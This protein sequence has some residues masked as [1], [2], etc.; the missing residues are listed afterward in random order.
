MQDSLKLIHESLEGILNKIH[1]AG[2]FSL[3]KTYNDE[4]LWAHY[5]NSHKGF[6]IE[7]DTNILTKNKK[8]GFDLISVH[9]AEKPPKITIQDFLDLK[10]KGYLGF[11]QKLIGT[12]SERWLYEQET[13]IITDKPGKQTYDYRAVKAIYFGLR[14]ADKDKENIMQRLAGRSISYF[15]M[16]LKEKAYLFEA[17]PINDPYENTPKY[18]YNIA[19]IAPDA[20]DEATRDDLKPF[21]TYLYKASEVARREPQCSKVEVVAFSLYQ[22]KP[23]HPIIYVNY[24]NLSQA[25]A[26]FYYSIEE[27]DQLYS[28]IEDL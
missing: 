19:P 20:I 18:L 4:L 23:G 22:S 25:D 9:Y 6:C 26:Q 16:R 28:E 12:K 11:M 17:T 7:F 13:R 15:Q 3:S 5:A 21:N 14:M 8:Y 10:K 24:L 1:D 2:V 27:I